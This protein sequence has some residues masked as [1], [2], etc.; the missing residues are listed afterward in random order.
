MFG[1]ENGIN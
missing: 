1:T